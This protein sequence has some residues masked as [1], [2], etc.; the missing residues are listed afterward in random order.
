MVTD[1]VALSPGESASDVLLAV[2]GVGDVRN[3][4][5]GK[6]FLDA[7]VV[8]RSDEDISRTFSLRIWDYQQVSDW[9]GPREI[10]RVKKVD[11][12]KFNDKKQFTT[13]GKLVDQQLLDMDTYMNLVP[14]SYWPKDYLVSGINEYIHKVSNPNYRSIVGH[15]YNLVHKQLAK[16]GL[17]L[18]E[19]PAAIGMH[20]AFVGGLMTHTLSMLKTAN[21]VLDNTIYQKYFDSS[22]IY[23]GILLHDLG[24]SFCYTNELDHESTVAGSLVDHIIII[25]GLI[26]QV[27]QDV[28]GV[29][30]LDLLNNNEFLKLRH[31]VLAHHGKLEWGSPIKPQ[32][33]E[34]WF[35]HQID[36][37]DA[38]FEVLRESIEDPQVNGQGFTGKIFPLDNSRLFLSKN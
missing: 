15:C 18:M 38:H 9:F 5:N 2:T 31:V 22:L 37:G 30:Y 20:H 26:C 13:E 32:L 33:P 16:Q 21:G 6:Q 8:Y 27:A 19:M 7:T 3:T 4:K 29:S 10:I 12:G 23:A 36:A 28:Y 11:V 24:K 34:A 17:D 1:V 25:D 35:I 14:G